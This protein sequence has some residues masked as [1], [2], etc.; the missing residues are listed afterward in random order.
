VTLD[1][2]VTLTEN[3]DWVLFGGTIDGAEDDTDVHPANLTTTVAGTINGDATNERNLSLTS[4]ADGTGT[5]ALGGVIGGAQGLGS[6]TIGQSDHRVASIAVNDLRAAGLVCMRTEPGDIEL[7]SITAHQVL[8]QAGGAIVSTG[9]DNN[10]TASELAMIAGSGIGSANPIGT[11]VGLLAAASQ[12]GAIRVAN[13]GNLTIGEVELC[14]TAVTGV[15]AGGAIE[16]STTGNLT[17]DEPVAAGVGDATLIGGA[18]GA[19]AAITID[20]SV[21]ASGAVAVLGGAGPDTITVNVTGASDLT[22]DGRGGNDQYVVQLGGMGV[23]NVRIADSGTTD[24]DRATVY[25][26]NEDDTLTVYNNP[27]NGEEQTGGFV[28]LD[29]GNRTVDYTGTLEFLTVLGLDGDDTVP[30]PAVADRGDHGQRR[31]P[32]FRPD[33]SAGG[34]YAGLRF[35]RQHL[36]TDLRDDPDGS[37]R[38]HGCP[39]SLPPG[40]LP[41]HR[42]HAA[43]SAGKLGAAAVRHGLE[44]GRDPQGGYNSVLPTAVYQPGATTYGWD[45]PLNGFDRG[46]TG[47][48]SEYTN[49]LR[50]GHWHSASRTF[51]A[52]VENGWYLVSIKTGDKSFARDRLRVTDANTVSEADPAGRI[53]LDNVSSP[54]GQIVERT[55][56]VFVPEGKN[57]ALTFANLGGDPYW[58]VNGIDIRPGKILTFGS[59][60]TD[61]KLSADGVTQTTF[62][63]YQATPGALITVDPQLDTQGDY[64]PEGTVTIVSPLDADPDVAGHQVRA[65]ADGVF[66]YTIVH[67]SVAGTLRV[68]YTE[69][70]GA[71]ASCFSVDFVAPSIRRFDFNSGASPIQTPAAQDGTPNGYVGVLPTQLSSPAVGYGWV[72]AAQGFDR[73]RSTVR[74]FELAARRGVG[75]LAAGLPHAVAAWADL[76]C[77]GHVRRRQFRAG[78]DERDGGD[79]QWGLGLGQRDERSHGGRPV[80]PSLVQGVA[81]RGR[82]GAAVQRRRRRSVLDGQRGRSAACVCRRSPSPPP[83]GNLPANGMNPTPGR[84]T[85]TSPTTRRG[86]GTR[87]HRRWGRSPR[88][89]AIR[90]M[91]GCKCRWPALTF[92]FSFQVAAGTIDG[93]ATVRVEEVN[94]ASRGGT[95]QNYVY[96]PVRRFDFNGSGVDTQGDATNPGG[97]CGA[98]T[99]TMRRSATAGMRRSASSSVARTG[100]ASRYWIRCTATGTGSR[101]RGRSRWPSIRP[102]PTTCGSTRATAASPETSCRSRSR[103]VWINRRSV[104]TAANEFKTIVVTNVTVGE[105]GILDIQIANLGG[106]PYWV[107]NGIEV[108]ESDPRVARAAGPAASGAVHG[109]AAVRL[110]HVVQ[111]GGFGVHPGRRQQ[112]LRPGAGLRLADRTAPTFSRGIANPLLRDGHWGTNNTFSVQVD[113][114]VE[115][116]KMYYVN[117]TLGDASFARN[118][119]S[120]WAEGSLQ[121]SGLATAAGQFIHRSFSVEVTDGQLNV[122]IASM[123]GDPYFTINALEVFETVTQ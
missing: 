59:P 71:Q 123:G 53:L 114:S 70:T 104:A 52:E 36:Y 43:G 6:V 103:V 122:Q 25:G 50:D 56:L 100:S 9:A 5:V 94:G 73:E 12:S 72:T 26:T 3:A 69:V 18:A 121:H 32:A 115:A 74:L 7:G 108:A 86:L 24:G 11:T 21:T 105:D 75:Q 15:A 62:T 22:L 102:R 117:V 77:D 30:C 57:L 2:A 64:R 33:R 109:D 107:I 44:L 39:K 51:T 38:R 90:G 93:T 55:F 42:E 41:Q 23:G 67:P 28:R 81:H 60:E 98:T 106:D 87:E 14:D 92:E 47:F 58:V 45:A 10:V 29:A 78:P 13:T 112:R 34:R 61:A 84:D 110:R 76:R 82:V 66:T 83:G 63:G 119:I 85:F 54:A 65:G 20:A 111:S 88:P 118:N 113:G 48:T 96:A 16:I 8:L 80:R 35:V 95:T 1:G 89:T 46:T 19:G 27:P 49:L 79:G 97:T 101:R 116:P 99:C 31:Q 91:Q 17:V 4:T 40:A 37:R 68:M 120:V